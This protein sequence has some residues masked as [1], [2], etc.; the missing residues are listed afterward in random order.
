MILVSHQEDNVHTHPPVQMNVAIIA[1]AMEVY[2]LMKISVNGASLLTHPTLATK[3]TTAALD[4][5]LMAIAVRQLLAM[6][7]LTQILA[8]TAQRIPSAALNAVLKASARTTEN[9][10]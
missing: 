3:M 2:A 9:V 6:D 1:V 7:A 10:S 5:A 8:T 4:V